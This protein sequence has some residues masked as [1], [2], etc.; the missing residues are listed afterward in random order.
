[1]R[2]AHVKLVR[3]RVGPDGA[4]LCCYC[5]S[6]IPRGRRDWCGDECVLRYQIA[7]GDQNACR[8]WLR[9]ETNWL[10]GRCG[11]S[12]RPDRWREGSSLLE[13][14]DRAGTRYPW[15]RTLPRWE[16]DHHIPL[17]EGGAHDPSNL[18]M[19]CVGC[20]RHVTREL[21]ARLARAR[22]ASRS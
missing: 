12:V 15:V 18:R 6:P 9:R 5:A 4:R 21:R 22:R 8:A 7:R 19:L 2:R 13:M 11:V 3:G 10:C 1:M 17:S 16:A 20:H 14:Q